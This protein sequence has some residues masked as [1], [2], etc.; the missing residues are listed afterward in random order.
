ME[1]YK[2]HVIVPEMLMKLKQGFG[3]LIRTE[4][5]TGVVAILDSRA[6]L[7]GAYRRRVLAALPDCRVTSNIGDIDSFMQGKKSPAY[8]A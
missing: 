1:E 5:D 3:R 6:N 2:S 8:F 4:T 7:Y